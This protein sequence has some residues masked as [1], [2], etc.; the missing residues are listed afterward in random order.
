MLDTTLNNLEKYE[1]EYSFVLGL[2]RAGI[3]LESIYTNDYN[4]SPSRYIYITIPYGRK[5]GGKSKVYK[6]F[7]NRDITNA[8]KFWKLTEKGQ[9]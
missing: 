6:R 2:K 3:P 8:I 7:S 4:N 1:R 5:N 9:G